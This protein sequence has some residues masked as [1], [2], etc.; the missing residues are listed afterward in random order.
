MMYVFG[1]SQKPSAVNV[2]K[3]VDEI[4]NAALAELKSLGFRKYGRTLH[5]FISDDISQVINFQSGMTAKGMSG[6]LCFNIGIRIP[7]CANVLFI[8]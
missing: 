3:T 4:E 7:E 8:L 1:F 5:R 6:L 2:T